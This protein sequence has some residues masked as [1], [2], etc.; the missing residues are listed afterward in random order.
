MLVLIMR[1]LRKRGCVIFFYSNVLGLYTEYTSASN[2][3]FSDMDRY[4]GYELL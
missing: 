1:Q 2:L 3:V 4:L